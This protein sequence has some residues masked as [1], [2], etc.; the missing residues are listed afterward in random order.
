[1]PRPSNRAASEGSS[2]G[3]GG[4]RGRGRGRGER[5]RRRL[6]GGDG[7]CGLTGGGG[8]GGG[9]DGGGGLEGG[10]G[11]RGGE[12]VVGGATAVEAKAGERAAAA[13]MS[14]V[15]TAVGHS[16]ISHSAPHTHGRPLSA[17]HTR[18][19]PR[20]DSWNGMMHASRTQVWPC[21][22]K[23]ANWR[24]GRLEGGGLEVALAALSS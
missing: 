20:V 7:L 21:R 8:L 9:V 17:T 13:A 24:G 10:G 15:A 19:S 12:R 1:M 23:E 3:G 14:G 16:L 22:S 5:R 6:W 2:H 4:M 11:G 18:A